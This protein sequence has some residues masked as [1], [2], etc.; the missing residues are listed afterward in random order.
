MA[1]LQFT[2]SIDK[3]ITYMEK[4]RRQSRPLRHGGSTLR[5]LRARRCF[6]DMIS[7][8]GTQMRVS[9]PWM[10]RQKYR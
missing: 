2:N 7:R 6:P 4:V 9:V 5:Q 10:Y 8:P 1:C 3:S